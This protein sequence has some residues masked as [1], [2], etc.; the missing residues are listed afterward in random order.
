MPVRYCLFVALS[1]LTLTAAPQL[2]LSTNTV[3]P[4]Y[5][6]VGSNAGSQT[7]NA[8]NLGDGS[9]NLSL[10]TSASWLSASLG[11]PTTCS[12]GPVSPCIP[13]NITLSTSALAIGTYT[14][15]LTVNDPNSIDAP[16]T[17]PVTLQV[18]GPPTSVDFYV[19]PYTGAATAQS[20]TA[21]LTVNTGGSVLSS[22]KTTDGG[23]WLN[24]V[25]I[26]G[27]QIYY[28]AWQLRVSAQVGQTEGNYSGMVILSGSM[29]PGD[30]K[31]INVNL[32]ITS[33]PIL[34]IPTAPITFN[35]VQGQAPQTYSVA[36]QNVGLGNLSIS[37]ASTAG[38]NWLSA[39]PAG[40]AT[41][42]ITA[43]P[44]SLSPGSYFG[45]V[46]LASNAANTAVPVPVRVNVS[47]PGPPT[48]AFSGVVDNAAF[49]SGQ[50]VAAGTIAAVFGT[51]LSATPPSY[52]GGFPLPTTLGGVQV[53]I[54][55]TPVPL[56]YADANQVDIQIPF[57]LSAGQVMV[58]I[59]RNGQ[60]GNHVTATVDSIAPRLFALRQMPS[61]PDSNPFGVVLNSDGTLAGSAHPAHRG[62]VLTI[63]ALGLGP[64]SPTVNTGDAA[65]SQE[66]L[67]RVNNQAQVIYGN[68]ATGSV[69]ATPT[70]AGLAPGFA[71][72]YQINVLLPA[73]APGGNVPVSINIA[74]RTSNLVDMSISPQ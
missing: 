19:T 47:A 64:A 1:T 31:T 45:A 26:G 29:F 16:Q 51:Q 9:L 30:N 48:V 10:A 52:A 69:T 44:G 46:T 21:S 58:Q 15:T 68:G 41:V 57:Y 62:D 70:Y 73:T 17:L 35:L 54:N 55:G 11:S 65:P 37:G 34:Q 72:L 25:S 53:L 20:A 23:G 61:A 22:V 33:Q 2:R 42:G 50:A 32:H 13:I 24:F 3:G 5:V 66:P 28:T 12:G 4:L 38:G 59:V 71:G 67:A 8:F 39:G 40:G 14:E 74:G 18:N 63:Y 6:E 7:V 27:N 49:A 43:N 60:P 56:V 36:F